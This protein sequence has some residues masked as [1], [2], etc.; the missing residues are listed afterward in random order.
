[1]KA[2]DKIF[3]NDNC[4]LQPKWATITSNDSVTVIAQPGF[5]GDFPPIKSNLEFLLAQQ[6]AMNVN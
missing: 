4:E 1:M 2:G 5:I 6:V 3:I